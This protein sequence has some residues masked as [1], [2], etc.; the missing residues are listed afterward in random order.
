M[1][2]KV[3]R[4]L[5]ILEKYKGFNYEVHI[6]GDELVITEIV[7]VQSIEIGDA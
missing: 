6:E 5:E 7:V 1:R 2:V 3:Y 4:L